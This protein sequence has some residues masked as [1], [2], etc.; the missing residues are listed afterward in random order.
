MKYEIGDTV[1]LTIV[2]NDK[3]MDVRVTL[4]EGIGQ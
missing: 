4:Q 3:E 1:K 2:R